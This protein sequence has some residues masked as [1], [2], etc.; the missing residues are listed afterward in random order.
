MRVSHAKITTFFINFLPPSRPPTSCTYGFVTQA[1]WGF[2]RRN[3]GR[4]E[5]RERERE[6]E[7]G[8]KRR[9]SVCE[10]VR[11]VVLPVPG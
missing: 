1:L 7:G 3:R 9:V 5:E 2:T 8:R 11:E 4:E 6:R 10:N